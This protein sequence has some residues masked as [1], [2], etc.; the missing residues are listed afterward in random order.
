MKP[1]KRAIHLD[2]HTMPGIYNFGEKWD[3]KEFA[4]ILKEAR[5]DYVNAFAKCNL[6]FTYYPTKLGIPYPTM[7]GDMF[8]ELLKECHRN[9]IGVSAYV[10]W[11]M[12]TQ[13]F[14]EIGAYKIRSGRLFM[15]TKQGTAFARCVIIADTVST[16]LVL[17]KKL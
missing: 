9:G 12:S 16:Y 6:G 1:M 15:G 8:G 10:N 5:V 17:L 11:I 4:Y 2:F 14:T 7:E 3:A 13:G